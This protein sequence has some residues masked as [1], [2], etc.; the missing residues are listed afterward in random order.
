MDDLKA[1]WAE[2]DRRREA[3]EAEMERR[4]LERG[5]R[6]LV[7]RLRDCGTFIATDGHPSY[8]PPHEEDAKE[9]AGEI[10]RLR[11]LLARLEWAG[12]ADDI[13]GG[14]PA[15]PACE[16]EEADPHGHESDCWLAAELMPTGG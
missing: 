3:H 2:R 13:T 16:A 4:R 7:E 1:R 10:E 14:N 5:S 8:A 12:W 15:C 6:P 11:G 9:A